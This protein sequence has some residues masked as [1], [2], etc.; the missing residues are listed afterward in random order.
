MSTT[1]YEK[2]SNARA[3]NLTKSYIL[4]NTGESVLNENGS[5]PI[6]LAIL[7]AVA[8]KITNT[9]LS[10]QIFIHTPDQQ[11]TQ[12]YDTCILHSPKTAFSFEC[13]YMSILIIT[14]MLPYQ[15]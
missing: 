5:M 12:I 2:I 9:F 11:K 14:Y 13:S 8:V 10:I 15:K 4:G 6:K 1:L 3:G 7:N